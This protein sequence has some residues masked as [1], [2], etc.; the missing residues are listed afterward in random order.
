MHIKY[1][2]GVE[3]NICLS[4]LLSGRLVLAEETLVDK[5]QEQLSYVQHDVFKQRKDDVEEHRTDDC[6][7]DCDEPSLVEVW[8][9]A[10][11]KVLERAT[12][13]FEV[14][15]HDHQHEACVAELGYE[16]G[17]GGVLHLL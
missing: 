16:D 14:G 1:W 2:T 6:I 15:V 17:V 12:L 11:Q 4:S 9:C 13:I 7:S 10:I 5:A 8:V 3:L